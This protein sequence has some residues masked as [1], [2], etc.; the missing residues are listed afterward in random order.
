MSTKTITYR[1]RTYTVPDWAKYI[2]QD[3]DGTVYVYSHAPVCYACGWDPADTYG[4]QSK[5]VFATDDAWKNS[6]EAI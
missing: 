6:L 3:G 1:G 4:S 5:R 2:A